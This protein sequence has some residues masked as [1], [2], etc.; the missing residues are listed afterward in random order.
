[1]LDEELPSSIGLVLG[2]GHQ[3][4]FGTML[5][6]KGRSLVL[7]NQHFGAIGQGL[8]TAIGA[9]VAS[10][11]TPVLLLEGDA[12]FLMYLS[13]FET[14][15]RYGLP[16]LVA[17]INDQALGSEYHKMESK[18]L[19]RALA[20]IPTPDLGAVA[21][22]MGGAGS[23]ITSLDELRVAVARFVSDPTPT[24]LDIRSSRQVLSVPY[25]RVH[26]ALDV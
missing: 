22:A 24:V 13:E 18:G 2:G 8:T 9:A 26:Q 12:G 5:M 17:V 10:P 20:L 14:A 1:M 16:L 25:R 7:A 4:N 3:V 19:D 23:R 6:A 11:D 21:T 15:V